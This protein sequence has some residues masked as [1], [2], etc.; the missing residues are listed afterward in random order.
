[1]KTQEKQMKRPWLVK[2]KKPGTHP[3]PACPLGRRARES[4]RPAHLSLSV[5]F[6][7][8]VRQ[9]REAL[10]RVVP[11]VSQTL[12]SPSSC[13]KDVAKPPSFQTEWTTLDAWLSGV[14][15]EIQHGYSE[16][17]PEQRNNGLQTGTW[18]LVEACSQACL[19]GPSSVCEDSELIS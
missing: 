11:Q 1:M 3:P 5:W 13:C 6:K 14:G 17:L 9:C 15:T 18:N 16:V 7:V 8:P 10:R 19:Q 12:A 2:G 4:V